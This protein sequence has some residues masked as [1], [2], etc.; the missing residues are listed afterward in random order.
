MQFRKTFGL[1]LA[2]V[3]VLSLVAAVQAQDGWE[4]SGYA[5]FRFESMDPDLH[6]DG[7]TDE[8]DVRRARVK[9]QGPVSDDTTFRI[10]FGIAGADDDGSDG[11]SLKDLYL[12][13]QINPDWVG[14]VGFGNMEFG[15]D[16]PYSSSS[17]LPFERCE[18]ADILL[19]G[20]RT[21]G[22]FFFYEPENDA[23]TP[24]VTLGISEDMAKYHRK[25]DGKRISIKE[26][27]ALS[28]RAEWPLQNDGSVGVS[29]L[30]SNADYW[31]WVP[32]AGQQP[33]Q[34]QTND[35]TDDIWGAW[36]RYNGVNGMGG[37]N[38]QG[39]YIDGSRGDVDSSGWYGLVE[40]TPA[41]S[42]GT[43]FFPYDTAETDGIDGDYT[44]NTLGYAYDIDSSQRLTA[45][46][47]DI[48]DMGDNSGTDYGVQWQI[49]Y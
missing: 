3:F 5:Q 9:M 38:F 31:E 12:K 41:D 24:M 20:E 28:A 16:V 17:R 49:K 1:L 25:D 13:R 7:A 43:F 35:F 37:L 8:F 32:A 39:E 44:S 36:I 45:Q 23:S 22:A 4:F 34:W 29:Y 14:R 6:G 48:D 40:F 47:K 10:Q 21:T 42:Q 15:F 26:A 33:A 18:I 2:T 46:M 11:I 19:D 30:T 27:L